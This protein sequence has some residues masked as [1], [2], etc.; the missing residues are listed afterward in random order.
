MGRWLLGCGRSPWAH[1]ST[2]IQEWLS[3]ISSQALVL[4]VFLSSCVCGHRSLLSTVHL[5][6]CSEVSVQQGE[7]QR[8]CTLQYHTLSPPIPKMDEIKEGQLPHSWPWKTVSSQLVSRKKKDGP[9]PPTP[10]L[11]VRPFWPPCQVRQL[12][13]VRSGCISP[14]G[15]GHFF[16]EYLVSMVLSLSRD[17]VSA[18]LC[19]PPGMHQGVAQAGRDGK[20][21]G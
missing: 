15:T 16:P 8:A 1:S 14:V 6:F 3:F 21:L 2:L 17:Q 9:D 13:V 20:E 19:P 18:R 7:N 4:G 5:W 10:A 11:T 12:Q